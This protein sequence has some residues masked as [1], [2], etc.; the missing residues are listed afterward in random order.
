M[1][2]AVPT[3]TEYEYCLNVLLY[4]ENVKN[5]VNIINEKCFICRNSN[6]IRTYLVN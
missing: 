5:T 2:N 1:L 3:L 4:Q 6:N